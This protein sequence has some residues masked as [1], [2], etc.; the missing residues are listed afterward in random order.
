MNSNNFLKS[1]KIRESKDNNKNRKTD[2]KD[3]NY[4]RS[5]ESNKKNGNQ[6]KDSQKKTKKKNKDKRIEF[7]LFLNKHKKIIQDLMVTYVNQ[8]ML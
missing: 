7:I 1:G 6:N 3:K 2:N 8:M 5:L 4:K